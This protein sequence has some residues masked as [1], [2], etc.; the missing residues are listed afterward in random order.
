MRDSA[1]FVAMTVGL[2]PNRVEF[3]AIYNGRFTSAYIRDGPSVSAV[4]FSVHQLGHEET[5][6]I[7]ALT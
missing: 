3:S 5:D 7:Y 6:G 1:A 2:R 4:P